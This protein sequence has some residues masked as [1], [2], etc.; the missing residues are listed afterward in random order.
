MIIITYYYHSCFIVLV[1]I[2]T[3]IVFI[4][5][6][7]QWDILGK[8]KI[9]TCIDLPILKPPV[10]GVYIYGD[11]LKC[12]GRFIWMYIY[13]YIYMYSNPIFPKKNGFHQE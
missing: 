5:V 2:T 8:I 10:E 6:D 9:E 1:T 7:T 4:I 11:I 12:M 13:I 3:I